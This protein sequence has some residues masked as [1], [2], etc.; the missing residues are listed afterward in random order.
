[1]MIETCSTFRGCVIHLACEGHQEPEAASLAEKFDEW[2]A[3]NINTSAD[4]E[5]LKHASELERA[6][7]AM[8]ATGRR[9]REWWPFLL[10]LGLGLLTAS[11]LCGLRASVVNHGHLGD[12]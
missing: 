3:R 2:V 8:D 6:I 9:R 7:E 12:Q 11:V 10:G 1:M 4:L 5:R